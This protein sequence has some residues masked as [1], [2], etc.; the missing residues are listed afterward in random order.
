MFLFSNSSKTSIP[1]AGRADA[2]IPMDP[3][4]ADVLVPVFFLDAFLEALL[5]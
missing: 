2:E 1:D 5:D 4:V 3:I